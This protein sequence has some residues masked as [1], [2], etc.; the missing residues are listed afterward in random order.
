MFI[1]QFSCLYYFV[2]IYMNE[3]ISLYECLAC[4]Q[5]CSLAYWRLLAPPPKF[6]PMTMQ[7][8]SSTVHISEDIIYYICFYIIFNLVYNF[9]YK[10]LLYYIKLYLP[11]IFYLKLYFICWIVLHNIVL[12]AIIYSLFHILYIYYCFIF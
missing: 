4:L 6:K 3:F 9:I 1:Y 10:C 11:I 2:F 5:S 12:F 7:T 8:G